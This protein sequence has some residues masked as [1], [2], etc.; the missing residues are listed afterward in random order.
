MIAYIKYM[1][2][3]GGT[4]K[5]DTEQQK[6]VQADKQELEKH[7]AEEKLQQT[8]QQKEK[9]IEMTSKE[10]ADLEAVVTGLT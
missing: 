8:I 7:R 9:K 1:L 5:V 6:Q 4:A 2:G 3:F 10:I